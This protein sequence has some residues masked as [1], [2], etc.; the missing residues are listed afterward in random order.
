MS[1]TEQ[2]FLR[3]DLA[4]D[5][6]AHRLAHSLGLDLK[7]DGSDAVLSRPASAG[8]PGRVGGP[9]RINQYA[10]P[11]GDPDDVSVLDGYD[12]VWEMW[13]TRHDDPVQRDEVRLLFEKVAARMPWPALLLTNLDLLLAAFDPATGVRWFP[14]GT[15]P[16]LEH[17]ALWSDYAID[18]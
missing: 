15:T 11:S 13:Y 4:P 12:L 17:R 18:R 2:I 5:E 14:E 6:A 16:D 1:D 3:C 9:L 10:D 7:V 8:R